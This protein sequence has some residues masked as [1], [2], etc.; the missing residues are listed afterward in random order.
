MASIAHFFDANRFMS[1]TGGATSASIAFYYS[2]TLNP[3]PVFTDVAL[4]TPAANPYP[5]AFGDIVPAL[6]LQPNVSYRRIITF[7]DATVQD[8]DPLPLS[9]N[10]LLSDPLGAGLVGFLASGAGAGATDLLARGRQVVYVTDYNSLATPILGDGV[11]D[12]APG[13]R[14]CISANPGKKIIF[15]NPSVGYLIGSSLGDIPQRT[16]L[17]GPGYKQPCLLRGFNGG[18]MANLLDGVAINS[19]TWDG[20]GAF[21][22]GGIVN[23]PLTHGNQ[24]VANSRFIEAT[25]GT[26]IHFNASTTQTSGSR[27]DW[28]NIEAYRRDGTAGSGNYAVV[29]DDPGVQTGGHPINMSNLKTGGF[30]SIDF[31][32]CNDFTL[33]GGA[34]FGFKTTPRSIG[35]HVNNVRIAPSAGVIQLYNGYYTNCGFS[36]EVQI[37]N[38]SFVRLDPSCYFNNQWADYTTGGSPSSVTSGIIY[39]YNPIIYAGATPITLGNGTIVAKWWRIDNTIYINVALTVGSS[40]TGMDA[41]LIAVTIPSNPNTPNVVGAHYS[42]SNQRDFDGAVALGGGG[43]RKIGAVMAASDRISLDYDGNLLGHAQP[44]SL[45]AA[46]TVIQISGSFVR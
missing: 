15:P 16:H 26:P 31:G 24:Q 7:P 44:V 8:L 40:T 22:T 29:H 28:R 32:A 12:D 34:I 21:F 17:E 41:G 46:G 9:N 45:T 30:D 13:I 39:N 27:S 36:L 42:L 19:M 18:Y 20:N 2:G 14:A 35:L 23:V 3:A 38:G 6:Y 33:E 11:N 25:G 4:T 43:Y 37:M 1:A 10:A 5:V